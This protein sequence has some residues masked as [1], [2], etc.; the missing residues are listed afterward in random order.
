MTCESQSYSPS[1]SKNAKVLADFRAAGL[2]IEVVAPRRAT[3]ATI[4]QAHSASYVARLLLLEA[5]NGFGNRSAAVARSLPFTVGAMVDA[6]LY[7]L[8]T[9]NTAMALASGFHHSQWDRSRAFCSL[10]GH[11]IAAIE[12]KKA[13]GLKIG[14]LDLDAHPSD[15]DSSIIAKLG[16]DFIEHYSVGYANFGHGQDAGIRFIAELPSIMERFRGCDVL[17]AQLAGDMWENDALNAGFLSFSQLRIRDRLVLEAAKRLGIGVA[18]SL[19]G[20]YPRAAANG[21]IP[22]LLRIHRQTAVEALRA[23][24]S[25]TGPAR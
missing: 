5:D 21:E 13:G 2:N 12:A 24:G 23:A 18:I 6:T 10:S 14:L 15:G 1:A 7:A 9:G 19:G 20:G 11:L 4:A 3:P 16:L 22:D 17:I 8:K 25:K